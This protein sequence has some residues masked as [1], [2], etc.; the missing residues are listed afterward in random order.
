M[1][2]LRLTAFRL[3]TVVAAV[4]VVAV[5]VSVPASAS[6][7]QTKTQVVRSLLSGTQIGDGW[8]KYAGGDGSA[9]EVGGCLTEATPSAG[10]RFT[11]SRSFQYQTT[12]AFADETVYAFGTATSARRDFNASKRLLDSCS[13]F[14]IDG[15]TWTVARMPV[16]AIADQT[17]RYRFNGSVPDAAGNKIPVVLFVVVTRYGRQEVTTSLGV[18][19]TLTSTDRTSFGKASVRLCRMATV[20][21]ANRLGR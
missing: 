7:A 16:A 20:K 17:V 3:T 19:G 2:R 18:G 4:T 10:L 12:A 9:A 8:H 1:G 15:N 11:A 14:T 6:V 21:V 13:S 5:A